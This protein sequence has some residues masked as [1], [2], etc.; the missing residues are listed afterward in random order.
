MELGGRTI[1][2]DEPIAVVFSSAN[3]DEAVFPNSGQFMINRPNIKDHIAFGSGPHRCP[4]AP[5]ARMMF[6]IALKELLVRTK[7][8]ELAGDITMTRWPEWGA[9][10]VP[11]KVDPA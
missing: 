3:R 6:Q 9:Q 11:L 7:H 4:G 10:S 2:K 8:I 1:R 5:L